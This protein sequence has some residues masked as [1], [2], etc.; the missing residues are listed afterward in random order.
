MQLQQTKKKLAKLYFLHN[1]EG[2]YPQNTYA[3][4]MFGTLPPYMALLC[5]ANFD[6][7]NI[8]SSILRE[9][10]WSLKETCSKQASSS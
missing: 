6:P 4:L 2:N 7:L 9:S 5:Y 10:I 8:L 3:P 1:P